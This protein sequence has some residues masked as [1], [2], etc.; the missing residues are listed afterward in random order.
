MKTRL[1]PCLIGRYPALA[2]IGDFLAAFFI[3]AFEE[4][5]GGCPCCIAVRILLFA[6]AASAVGFIVGAYL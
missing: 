1:N 3:D 4:P 6:A 2:P 5:T